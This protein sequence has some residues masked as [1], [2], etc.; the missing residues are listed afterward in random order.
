LSASAQ[1]R[2]I[3][4]RSRI[5]HDSSEEVPAQNPF[6]DDSK[7]VGSNQPS[8][9][10]DPASGRHLL[11]SEEEQ[12]HT[13]DQI[14]IRDWSLEW[15]AWLVAAMSLVSLI[16][17]FA[18]YSDKPLR[19]WKAAITPGTT[20][21][22]LSQLGQTSILAPVTACICQSMWLWLDKESRVTHRATSDGCY[23]RLI[24]MQTYDDGSRGPISSLILLWKQ[25]CS[26]EPS[27]PFHM[28]MLT[29]G[30]LLIW[31]G[32]ANT[33]LIIIF[34][35]FAQQSLQLPTR[36]FN[37]TDDGNNWIPRTLQY[38]AP[39][40]AVNQPVIP[41]TLNTIAYESVP[42][43]MSVAIIDGLLGK[44]ISPSNVVGSCG[45][46][47]CTWEDYQSLGVCSTVVD[48]SST[49]TS[50][51]RKQKT[52]FKQPGCT[53]SIPAI[54]QN[55]TARHTTL[56]TYKFGETLWVGASDTPNY[57]SPGLNT[58]VQ[59]YVIYVSDFTRWD[60][61]DFTEDHK[62]EL[63]ALQATLSLCVKKY[64]TD[65]TFGVTDTTL[66]GKETELDWQ[67]SSEVL[68]GT[69]FETLT[70]TH[71]GEEF[72]MAESNQH[73]LYKY[74]SIQTFTGSASMRSDGPDGGGNFSE[75]DIYVECTTYYN[76][77]A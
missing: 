11:S 3:P 72:V 4:S 69:S 43:A 59:F 13:R 61:L 30:R 46:G 16:I 41:G 47:N 38:R 77:L 62:D 26:Y 51:C 63:V 45:T 2:T 73:S 36:E 39:R 9:S 48:V 6:A 17:V 28:E 76:R 70:A 20:V 67:T 34:G 65:M 64:H 29:Y 54:D 40:P 10:Y 60:D 24:T 71:D 52:Q 58:L 75:S 23:R 21:A 22:I 33:L 68:E 50:T 15:T 12:F 31:L 44:D 5:F 49:I 74:L 37:V 32:T 35:S 7:N 56:E 14:V 19:Q 42:D 53:Y 55:P 1:N 66:L 8:H 27:I 25:P 57:K 18:I